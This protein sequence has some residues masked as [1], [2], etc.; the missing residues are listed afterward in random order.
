MFDVI[1]SIQMKAAVKRGKSSEES[2]TCD[3][4]P[5]MLPQQVQQDRVK[6]NYEGLIALPLVSHTHNIKHL[7]LS[8][9][10]ITSLRGV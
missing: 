10:K 4:Q 9:N 6:H 2:D 7:Y 1:K 5:R 3:S 8:H